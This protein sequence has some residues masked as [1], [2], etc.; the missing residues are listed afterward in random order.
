MRDIRAELLAE[1]AHGPD[2]HIGQL[3]MLAA[4]K[5]R[6]LEN[7]VEDLRALAKAVRSVV[8]GPKPPKE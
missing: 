7:E 4:E 3:A 5:I 1:H 8:N 6:Q 2:T